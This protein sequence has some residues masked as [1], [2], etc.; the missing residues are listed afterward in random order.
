[1]RVLAIDT[2]VEACSLAYSDGAG[3]VWHRSEPM[4]RGHAERL[5]PLF[6]ELKSEINW[7]GAHTPDRIVATTGPGTF[8][9]T[10]I[11]L[12]TAPSRT[13]TVAMIVP[14]DQEPQVEDFQFEVIE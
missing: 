5:F 10:R 4:T 7:G 9:G 14:T 2:A 3:G 11:A 6:D 13:T 1:M 8:T 12:A